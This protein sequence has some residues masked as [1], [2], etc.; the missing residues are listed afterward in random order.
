MKAISAK[1]VSIDGNGHQVVDAFI[2][3]DTI[4][5]PLPTTGENI[6][7]MSAND[8]FA[9]FSILYIVNDADTK[10]FI[11]DESGAFIAQ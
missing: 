3:S 2:V 10:L 5:S 7:G 1:P 4:P 11:A 9:P 8:V 6:D